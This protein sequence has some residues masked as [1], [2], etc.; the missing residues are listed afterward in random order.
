MRGDPRSCPASAASAASTLRRRI[1]R[2]PC[3]VH[4]SLI[5]TPA[6]ARAAPRLRAVD[7]RCRQHVHLSAHEEAVVNA[8]ATAATAAAVAA[9]AAVAAGLCAAAWV[10]GGVLATSPR[11]PP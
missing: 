2:R 9:V 10:G 3:L 4:R 1:A 5:G 7:A 8:A 11:L 6:G